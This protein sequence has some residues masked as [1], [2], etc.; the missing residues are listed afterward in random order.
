MNSKLSSGKGST[1]LTFNINRKPSKTP[2][3]YSRSKLANQMMKGS[4]LNNPYI[5]IPSEVKKKIEE[6][7]QKLKV[8]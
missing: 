4:R 7:T 6:E 2:S 8:T 1:N 3:D 5:P